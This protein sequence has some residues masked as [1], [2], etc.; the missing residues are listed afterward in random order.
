[1]RAKMLAK[2]TSKSGTSGKAIKKAQKEFCSLIFM[3]CL[4]I[5]S[6]E[7]NQHLKICYKPHAMRKAKLMTLICRCQLFVWIMD[8][9]IQK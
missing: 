4:M 3:Q 8:R 2:E 7:E 9:N 5:I 1:M 6:N